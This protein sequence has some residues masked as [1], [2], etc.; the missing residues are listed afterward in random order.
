MVERRRAQ[1]DEHLA[2][3]GRRIG[4]LLVAQHLGPAVLV[5]PDGLHGGIVSFGLR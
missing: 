3:A 5:D 4:N 1:A 2:R